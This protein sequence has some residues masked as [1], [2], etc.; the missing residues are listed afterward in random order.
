MPLVRDSFNGTVT[1][2]NYSNPAAPV[3]VV[4]GASGDDEGLTSDFKQPQPSWSAV[5]AP[6]LGFARMH[7]YNASCM[8]FAWINA[9]T[10]RVHDNFT[11]T[12][13]H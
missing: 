6:V 7:F 2:Y 8:Q 3:H 11:L 12:K 9:D 1:Q 13:Y 5:R 10:G 4:I